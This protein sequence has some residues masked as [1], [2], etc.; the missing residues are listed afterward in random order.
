MTRPILLLVG[1]ALVV[2]AIGVIALDST[3]GDDTNPVETFEVSHAATVLSAF[4]P[5]L[6]Q[7]PHDT[8][9]YM[10]R[11]QSTVL[12]Q[13]AGIVIEPP[14]TNSTAVRVSLKFIGANRAP[15]VS[16]L[17]PLMTS[18]AFRGVRYHDLYEGIDLVVSSE[19]GSIAGQ[20]RLAPHV[21]PDL[22]LFRFEGT[23]KRLVGPPAAYQEIDGLRIPVRSTFA[24]GRFGSRRLE[25]GPYDEGRSVMVDFGIDL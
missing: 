22:I 1:G 17:D 21:D 18:S 2:F 15:R 14:P 25:L 3:S 6:G 8:Y 5:N 20:L 24:S 16:G 10:R 13:T 19:D 23:D 12:L 7:V 11:V 9:F 4:A